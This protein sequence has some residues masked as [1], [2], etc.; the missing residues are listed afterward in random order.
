VLNW[1]RSLAEATKCTELGPDWAKGYLRVAT[2]RPPPLC[3]KFSTLFISTTCH[4]GDVY[5]TFSR[6]LASCGAVLKALKALTVRC[7]ETKYG[8]ITRT[9]P[10]SVGGHVRT[11]FFVV[12]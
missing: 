5:I 4:K 10:C 8:M 7:G 12:F 3:T 9:T 2:V 1:A 11:Q 6:A